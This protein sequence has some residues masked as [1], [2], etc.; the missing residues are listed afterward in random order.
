VPSITKSTDS[1]FLAI[2]FETATNERSS[3]CS[4]GL[5]LVENGLIVDNEHYLIRPPQKQFNPWCVRQHNITFDDVRDA[6]TFADVWPEVKHL[7]KQAKY[8]VAHNAAFDR[9]VLSS[10]L[11]W[12]NLKPPA[13]KFGCTLQLAKKVWGLPSGK[14]PDVCRAKKV[15]PPKHHD[16][17]EDAW[18]CARLAIKG[19]KS[20]WQPELN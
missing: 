12:Y 9:S 17:L 16:A 13:T 19:L 3:A 14:L 10:T 8:F 20:G 18:A 15:A 6:G 5:V 1:T 11:Q 2:D 4:V 7:F